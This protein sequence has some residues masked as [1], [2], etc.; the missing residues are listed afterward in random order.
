M[1][2]PPMNLKFIPLTGRFLSLEP[3]AP[4]LKNEVR[5]A[6]DCDA[7]SWAIMPV[8]PTGD[9]FD[10]YWSAACGA[11]PESADGIRDPTAQR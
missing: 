4:H 11:P 10:A 9:G 6:V 2:L 1:P 7:D 8:N 3:F 5:A